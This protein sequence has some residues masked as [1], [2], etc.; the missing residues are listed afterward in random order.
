[1]QLYSDFIKGMNSHHQEILKLELIAITGWDL[2]LNPSG[3][4]VSVF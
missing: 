1:M 4:E 3:E 2:G